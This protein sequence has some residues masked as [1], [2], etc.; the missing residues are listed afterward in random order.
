L[1]EGRSRDRYVKIFTFT[2]QSDDGQKIFVVKIGI[3]VYIS[4]IEE[5]SIAERSGLR[6]GD[7]ILEVNGTPFSGMTHDEALTVNDMSFAFLTIQCACGIN[8]RKKLSST[9]GP[10]TLSF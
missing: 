9:C 5:N 4:R 1:C 10:E 8:V 3:G 2:I 6:P 7:T